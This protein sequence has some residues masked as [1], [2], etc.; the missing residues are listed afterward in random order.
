MYSYA[1]L[2]A[3]IR[4]DLMFVLFYEQQ[5]EMDVNEPVKAEPMDEAPT[6]MDVGETSYAAQ[7]DTSARPAPSALITPP[8]SIGNGGRKISLTTPTTPVLHSAVSS[9]S[10]TPKPAPSFIGRTMDPPTVAPNSN[11]AAPNSNHTSSSV[12]GGTSNSTSSVQ[13][14]YI[15]P[16]PGSVSIPPWRLSQ[17]GNHLKS[18]SHSNASY[19][20][21]QTGVSSS[22]RIGPPVSLSAGASIS[23]SGSG[24]LPRPSVNSSAPTGPALYNFAIPVGPANRPTSSNPVVLNMGEAA[25]VSHVDIANR[26]VVLQGVP[27]PP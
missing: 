14:S 27:Q 21:P 5:A 17:P 4:Y 23:G 25:A 19:S 10:A 15:P 22:N 11:L 24:V 18:N 8:T 7:T 12:E 20:Q 16:P 26:K 6:K 2:K 13:R 1:N 9:T 3:R